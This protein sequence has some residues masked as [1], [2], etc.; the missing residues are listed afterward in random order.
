MVGTLHDAL[1]KR[2]TSQTQ[3]TLGVGGRGKG[4]PEEESLR[5]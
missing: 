3:E 5:M 4:L 2:Y 1:T